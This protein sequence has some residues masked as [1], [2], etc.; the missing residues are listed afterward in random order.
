MTVTISTT[1]YIIIKIS[2]DSILMKIR[3]NDGKILNIKT[4]KLDI[5]IIRISI[6]L[7][8]CLQAK[9]DRNLPFTP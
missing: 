7:R 2:Y 8:Q 6:L 5:E 4:Q 9:F 3:H 1:D